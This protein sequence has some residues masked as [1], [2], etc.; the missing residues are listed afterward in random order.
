MEALPLL[1]LLALGAD[2]IFL[3]ADTLCS[4]GVFAQLVSARRTGFAYLFQLC[5]Q[6]HL[7]R[8][9]LCRG[10]GGEI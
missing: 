7:L 2:G 5:F 4:G 1:T 3:L 10:R 6:L 9:K 8:F